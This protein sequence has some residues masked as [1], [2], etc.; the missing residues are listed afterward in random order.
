MDITS[1]TKTGETTRSDG[2]KAELTYNL[3]LATHGDNACRS[4]QAV[5]NMKNGESTSM[6][7]W[8]NYNDMESALDEFGLNYT[9]AMPPSIATGATIDFWDPRAVENKT[10]NADGY[11]GGGD[12]VCK[13]DV[14]D[15]C[16][17][18][19]GPVSDGRWEFNFTIRA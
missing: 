7:H 1:F 12:T 19:A 13:V 4:D 15:F 14:Q 8:L 10:S 5:M 11:V 3:K 2:V 9:V 18:E 16:L 17:V 6:V